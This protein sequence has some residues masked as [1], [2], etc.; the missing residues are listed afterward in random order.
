MTTAHPTSVLWNETWMGQGFNYA[1]M[2]TSCIL[3]ML[4]VKNGIIKK[5]F[6]LVLEYMY[7]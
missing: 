6:W 1:L 7:W 2:G 3:E 5:L 4:I